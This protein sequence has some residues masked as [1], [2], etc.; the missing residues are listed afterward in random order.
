MMR[1]TRTIFILL[2]IGVLL[3][4]CSGQQAPKS[5]P[6]RP[7]DEAGAI[8][9]VKEINEAQTNYIRRTRRYAQRNE[10]LIAEKLLAKEPLVEGYTISMLPSPDAGSYTV[11]A[12]PDSAEGKHLFSDLT[13]V[14]RFEVGKPATKESPTN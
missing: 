5:K 3:C 8:A 14:I 2:V 10:E 13:E 12:T 11:T 4:A 1:S 6:S 9:A 7:A